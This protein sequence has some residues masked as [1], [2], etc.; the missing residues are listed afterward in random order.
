MVLVVVVTGGGWRCRVKWSRLLFD[1][2]VNLGTYTVLRLAAALIFV[3]V[4]LSAC[5]G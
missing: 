1:T 2:T 4:A 3:S 5:V